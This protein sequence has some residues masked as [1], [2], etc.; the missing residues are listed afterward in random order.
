M[1]K[2]ILG[3]FTHLYF[4]D[5]KTWTKEYVEFTQD[6]NG[7]L[8]IGIRTPYHGLKLPLM[9]QAHINK[10]QSS[11]ELE[12]LILTRALYP[13]GSV[14]VDTEAE[15][16]RFTILTGLSRN[17][18]AQRDSFLYH[19]LYFERSIQKDHY[20]DHVVFHADGSRNINLARSKYL[21]DFPP[22]GENVETHGGMYSFPSA[23]RSS[24]LADPRSLEAIIKN[25]KSRSDAKKLAD[26]GRIK[27]LV[28][29]L[30]ELVQKVA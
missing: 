16:P 2:E 6:D 11:E 28:R 8:V 23:A 24:E 1:L 29:R 9:S 5:A 27:K 19:A 3:Y 20:L 26:E 18:F 4:E 22:D 14:E 30:K 15:Q 12:A 13:Q 10:I 21:D 17:Y 7:V 25:L